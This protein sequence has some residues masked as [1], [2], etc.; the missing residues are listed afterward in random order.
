MNKIYKPYT[1]AIGWSKYKIWYYGVR[2]SKK[3]YVGDIWVEYF[4]SST[5]V[6]E[7]VKN[8]GN[9]DII[10]ICRVFDNIDD[11]ILHEY[12]FLSKVKV[13]KNPHFLNAHCAPAFKK[14]DENPMKI[15][16]IRE[17]VKRTKTLQNLIK[18]VRNKNFK[19]HPSKIPI[20]EKYIKILMNRNRSYKRIL[21]LLNDR[22]QLC[23]QWVPK[24]YPKNRLSKKRGPNTK[25]SDSKK[26]KVCYHN[27]LTKMGK[28]FG[29]NDIIP[30]GWLK[31]LV[32]N[33]PNTN[34]PEVKKKISDSQKLY[35]LKE[36]EEKKKQRISKWR[37]TTTKKDGDINYEL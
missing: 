35:R 33:T 1:Y 6:K 26:G 24:P 27:P 8:N 21:K 25:I 31:G 28:M 34:T 4:T 2:I 22:I 19:L 15:G 16:K 7:F 11:A 30:D 14:F 12:K 36:S 18:N 23:S 17:K 5:I 13:H 32:K 29:S 37:E 9:P 10:K 20:L 3:S